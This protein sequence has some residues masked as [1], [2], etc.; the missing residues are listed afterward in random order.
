MNREQLAHAIRTACALTRRDSVIVV[1]SQ[2]ILGSWPEDDLPDAAT[3]SREADILAEGA[4]PDETR[5]NADIITGVAGELSPFDDTHKFHL[6][7][8]DETTAILP[9]GWRTRLVKF[10]NQSTVDQVTEEEYTGWC[11]E[12]HDLCV[13]KLCAGRGKDRTFVN[14]IIEARLVDPDLLRERLQSLPVHLK[15]KAVRAESFIIDPGYK[16]PTSQ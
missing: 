4:T 13:A 9:H 3:R 6:D 12:P 5:S 8:V 10:A 16:R 14:A 2:S 1:G 11:L 7:G 15:P